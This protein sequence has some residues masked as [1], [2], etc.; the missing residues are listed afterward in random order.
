MRAT[1][2][3]PISIGVI[4]MAAG[5]ALGLFAFLAPA[6]SPTE[7]TS[8]AAGLIGTAAYASEGVEVGT[9]TAVTVGDDGQIV[10]VCITAAMVP[11]LQARTVAFRRGSFTVASGAVVLGLSAWEVEMFP[12]PAPPRP[13]ELSI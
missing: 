11:G 12:R 13:A 8:L 10:E 9:V 6:P 5:M 3:Q 1:L 4:A 2:T 7:E